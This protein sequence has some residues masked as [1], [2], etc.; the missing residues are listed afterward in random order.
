M[1]LTTKEDPASRNERLD[2]S[3]I[4]S[5]HLLHALFM[6]AIY[7]RVCYSVHITAHGAE[8]VIAGDSAAGIVE[9][10]E[11]GSTRPKRSLLDLSDHANLQI[12]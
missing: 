5:A 12:L 11:R 2:M 10:K 4:A 1:T 3:V 7:E 9:Q 8:S 6:I